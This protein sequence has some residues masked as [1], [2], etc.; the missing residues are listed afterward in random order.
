VL[1]RFS[2]AIINAYNQIS[3]AAKY[4]Q[5]A[6]IVI[7]LHDI[8]NAK[9][10]ADKI[11]LL[12]NWR[13]LIRLSD[14]LDGPD[15]PCISLTFDDGYEDWVDR[16][17]P[18]L[19]EFNVPAVFFVN[20]GLVGLDSESQKRFKEQNLRRMRDVE[21]LSLNALHELAQ[22]PLVEIGGH[23]SNHLDL[24]SNIRGEI[25]HWEVEEDKKSL[26]AMTGKRVRYFSYPYGM[27]KNIPNNAGDLLIKC[28]YEAAFTILSGEVKGSDDPFFLP[29]ISLDLDDPWYVW[30]A[31]LSKAW[32]G[33]SSFKRS[34]D[35]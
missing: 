14:L 22:D 20:S 19:R 10:F 35:L 5:P 30:Q 12:N 27:E 3:K 23:T 2:C 13:S 28:G 21:L 16:A 18:I 31:K 26:E 4:R 24:G 7:A 11:K 29:R 34:L 8:P 6:S 9:T 25:W 32:F 17:L 33:L 1:V 15:R